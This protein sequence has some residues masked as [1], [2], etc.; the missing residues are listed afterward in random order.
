MTGYPSHLKP[1]LAT[2]GTL[3]R[4]R[5][6]SSTLAN[7]PREVAEAGLRPPALLV[8]GEVVRRRPALRWIW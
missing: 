2:T 7:L 6:V 1:M 4:Q 3:P 5:T 8:I